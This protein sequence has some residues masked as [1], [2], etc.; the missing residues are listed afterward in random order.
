MIGLQE[1]FVDPFGGIVNAAIGPVEEEVHE[2]AVTGHNA[3][4]IAQGSYKLILQQ[5]VAGIVHA[6]PKVQ[7][8][9]FGNRSAGEERI[10]ETSLTVLSAEIEPE[11][12]L[13]LRHRR[14]VVGVDASDV[15]AARDSDPSVYLKPTVVFRP[16][17]LHGHRAFPRQS[18]IQRVAR[19][20]LHNP[21]TAIEIVGRSDQ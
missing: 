16:N 6:R 21:R 8:V 17:P 10:P 3:D 13:A 9:E 20:E 14:C 18:M 12:V 19:R 11:G 15:V 7:G 4:L 1:I 5:R 2:G